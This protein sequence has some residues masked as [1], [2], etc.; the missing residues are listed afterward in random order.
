MAPSYRQRLVQLLV[1]DAELGGPGGGV[2]TELG[3]HI[4]RVADRHVGPRGA[5]ARIDADAHLAARRQA[6]ETLELAEQVD[7]DLDRVAQDGGEV[8]VGDVGARVADLLR[9]PAVLERPLELAG[10]AHVHAYAARRPR[11]AQTAQEGQHLGLS[12]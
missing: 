2:L 9:E 1:V 8:L 3:V 4:R 6:A 7:V 11:L 5:G 12:L 10:R